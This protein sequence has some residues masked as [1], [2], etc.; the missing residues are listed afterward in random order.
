M[1]IPGLYMYTAMAWRFKYHSV[2][3]MVPRQLWMRSVVSSRRKGHGAL[4]HLSCSSWIAGAQREQRMQAPAPSAHPDT[5]S[6]A[7][8]ASKAGLPPGPSLWLPAP[9]AHDHDAMIQSAAV[10]E[11]PVHYIG[12]GLHATSQGM[13]TLQPDAVIGN[14]P[15]GMLSKVPGLAL[16]SSNSGLDRLEDVGAL[17]ELLWQ[18]SPQ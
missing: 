4:S 11:S 8:C 5:L 13:R 17:L 12:S 6:S 10:I 7:D 9:P 16:Q 15:Q 2:G 3:A 18:A 1:Q 14:I